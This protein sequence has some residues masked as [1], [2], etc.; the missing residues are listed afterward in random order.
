MQ[1][2]ID[3]IHA[4]GAE[5]LAISSEPG[6]EGLRIVRDHGVT[7]PLLSDPEL[8]AIV[9]YGVRHIGG[10]PFDDR[11]VARPAVFILDREGRVTWRN[12]TGNWRVRVHPDQVVE[13][14]RG[15]P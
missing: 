1:S 7:F 9:A 13:V 10:Y 4:L 8:T 15:I 11:V 6:S 14:L 5:V 3:E 2:R 12:L